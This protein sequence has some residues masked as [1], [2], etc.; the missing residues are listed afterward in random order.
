MPQEGRLLYQK[1]VDI[2][3]CPL[4]CIF[5]NYVLVP[6]LVSQSLYFS[7]NL[8][9][10]ES[11]SMPSP[12]C[13]SLL[14]Q[15]TGSSSQAELRQ[16]TLGVNSQQQVTGRLGNTYTFIYATPTMP[17]VGTQ[18]PVSADSHAEPL[19]RPGHLCTSIKMEC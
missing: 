10:A 12:L 1:A 3:P 16:R 13:L 15:S 8:N 9:A 17:M 7:V 14:Q 18:G 19:P 2:P 6:G 4:P 11:V 5:Q